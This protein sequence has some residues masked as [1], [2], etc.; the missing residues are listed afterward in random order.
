M[1]N[2]LFVDDQAD[3][4]AYAAELAKV[5]V[6]VDHVQPSAARK[7]LLDQNPSLAGV[8]MDVDLSGEVGMLGTGLGLA[9]D[10]RARQKNG[11]LEDFPIIRFANPGPIAKNV[12]GDPTSDDL[13]DDYLFKAEVGR[14]AQ[15]VAA[16]LGL[17]ETVYGAYHKFKRERQAGKADVKFVEELLGLTGDQ[18]EEWVHGALTT[19]LA[20]GFV[21][22]IHV[23]AGTFLRSC[24][25]A[26]GV[27]VD[28]QT[29]AMRLGLSANQ[30]T[31]NTIEKWL[32]TSKYRGVGADFAERWWSSGVDQAWYSLDGAS[33]PLSATP[34][35][36]RLKI[37]SRSLKDKF[38]PLKMPE[39]SPG[40]KPW[41]WCQLSLERDEPEYIPVDPSRGIKLTLPNDLPA[42]VDPLM[43]SFGVAI[44]QRE[45][46]R[47]S[48]AD[49][50]KLR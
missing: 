49:R 44:R 10:V 46:T 32:A 5:N 39:T 34:V 33:S 13:F 24:F 41:R 30:E 45:D 28:R 27:M 1:A 17:T 11:G 37:L 40:E 26:V 25:N 50:E 43:A 18:L 12:R 47:I 16:R 19:R 38:I 22:P 21:G 36:D 4:V 7:L 14:S 31:W 42:W 48:A 35:D 8:L 2:W 6:K 20:S 3:A 15:S 29:L 9:Q 23:A